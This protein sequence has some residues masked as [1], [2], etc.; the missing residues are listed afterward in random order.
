MNIIVVYIGVYSR[1][2]GTRPSAVFISK[3]VK[4]SKKNFGNKTYIEEEGNNKMFG[5]RSLGGRLGGETP[6][7]RKKT[8]AQYYS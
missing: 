7:G 1:L 8:A 6:T 3:P 2:C 5:A 4:N